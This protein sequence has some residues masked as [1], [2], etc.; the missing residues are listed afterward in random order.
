MTHPFSWLP[1][2]HRWRALIA[3]S[4]LS[5]GLMIV[6]SVASAP[7]HTDAAPQGIVSYEFAGDA[8]TAAAML[9]SWD[10]R[11]RLLNA[12]TIGLDYLFLFVYSLSI[13]L[14]CGMLA[15]R[16]SGGFAK[17]LALLAWGQLAAAGFD[18]VENY[19]LL[20][21]LLGAEGDA[22]PALA[23]ACAIPKFA[24]VGAGLVAAAVSGVRQLMRSTARQR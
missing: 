16:E 17:L 9:D 5:V 19:A 11:A 10:E 12:F 3:L 1:A 22:W 13:A 14:A 20:R 18:A 21:V 23:R 2:A 7:M 24:L 6:L 15:E 8:A 4:L